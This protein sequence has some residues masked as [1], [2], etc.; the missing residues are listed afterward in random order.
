MMFA[1][2]G[3]QIGEMLARQV[4]MNI[5]DFFDLSYLGTVGWKRISDQYLIGFIVPTT[6]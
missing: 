5:D 2:R 4:R 1:T 6:W 3:T